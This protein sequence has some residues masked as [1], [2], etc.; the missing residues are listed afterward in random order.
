MLFEGLIVYNI[1]TQIKENKK[2]NS[3]KK[4]KQFCQIIKLKKTII[5]QFFPA[6]FR[7]KRLAKI[8][9]AKKLLVKCW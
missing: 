5:W 3:L 9:V 1:L 8:S 2:S 6:Y 4:K 7:M